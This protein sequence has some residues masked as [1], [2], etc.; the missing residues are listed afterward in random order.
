MSA[1]IFINVRGELS[2]SNDIPYIKYFELCS[3]ENWSLQHYVSLII[4]NYKFAKKDKTHYYFFD[5]LHHISNNLHLMGPYRQVLVPI[6]YMSSRNYASTEM[7]AFVDSEGGFNY[8]PSF[9]LS[10]HLP[11]K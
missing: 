3:Y 6:G 11:M 1:I 5:T 7:D 2:T 8:V 10:G 4:D 9:T